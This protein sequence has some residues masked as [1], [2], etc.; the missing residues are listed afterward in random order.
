MKQMVGQM[1]TR[2]PPGTAE[3]NAWVPA[4]N[5]SPATSHTSAWFAAGR[6]VCINSTMP[7][8]AAR[9]ITTL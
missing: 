4:S 2:S 9:P 8:A 7:T 3:T 1:T 5:D 6:P